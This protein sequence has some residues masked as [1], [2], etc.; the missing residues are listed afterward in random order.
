MSDE[1]YGPFAYGPYNAPESVCED[2]ADT[3][4]WS[5]WL[6]MSENFER[7]EWHWHCVREPYQIGPDYAP[8]CSVPKFW[9]QDEDRATLYVLRWSGLV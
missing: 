3:V 6:W 4:W 8:I 1:R 5:C 2:D 7:H 9:F